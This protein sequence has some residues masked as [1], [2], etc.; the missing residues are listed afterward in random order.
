MFSCHPSVFVYRPIVFTNIIGRYEKILCA[1]YCLDSL[2]HISYCKANTLK[3]PIPNND[4]RNKDFI[5]L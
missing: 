1:M 5:H 2:A 4:T 3:V